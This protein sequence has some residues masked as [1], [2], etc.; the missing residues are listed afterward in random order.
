MT[1]RKASKK[2]GM[3]RRHWLADDSGATAVE[4]GLLALPFFTII[5]AIMQTSIIFLAG[6]VLESAVY[7]ASRDIRTGLVQQ[8]GGTLATFRTDVCNRLFGLFPN[9]A[10]LHIRVSELTNFQTATVQVP[11]DASCTTACTWTKPEAFSPG[12]GKSIVQ[13]QVFYRYPVIVQL[14]PMGMSNLGDGSR[15]LGTATVFQNEPFT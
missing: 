10:G 12:V 13:V 8:T 7:D 9:C 4:F 15:L 14:G 5:A 1:G 3:S 11:V 2:P 6:Q